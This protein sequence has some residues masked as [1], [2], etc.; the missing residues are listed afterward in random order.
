MY[1]WVLR[2]DP[3]IRLPSGFLLKIEFSESTRV[4]IFHQHDLGII[5]VEV[6]VPFSM[7]LS[8]FFE[9]F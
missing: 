9:Y 3:G 7:T 6:C 5:P 1:F 4:A 8:F 2:P